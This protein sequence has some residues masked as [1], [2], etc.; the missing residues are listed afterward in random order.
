MIP[1]VG[2]SI[3]ISLFCILVAINSNRLS[4]L[5]NSWHTRSGNE[6]SGSDEGRLGDEE[7]QRSDKKGRRKWSLHRAI[8]AIFQQ[9][10]KPKE[11]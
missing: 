1:P 7:N 10:S 4:D 8:K 2:I 5:F 9:R 6:N 3:G 11:S